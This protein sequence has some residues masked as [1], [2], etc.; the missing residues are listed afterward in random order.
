MTPK[1]RK[2]LEHQAIPKITTQFH[3]LLDVGWY[4]SA[5]QLAKIWLTIF[6]ALMGVLIAIGQLGIAFGPLIGGA[7]TQ[8]FYV[9]LPIGAVVGALLVFIYIPER[10]TKPALRTVL[11]T[12]IESLDL[13]G[14]TI[15][16]PASIMFLLALQYGGNEYAWNSATVIGLLCG[17]AATFV[18]FLSWEY[19]KGDDAMIPFSMISQK[20]LWSASVTMF[21]FLGALFCSNYYLP[22]YFQAVKNASPTMSGVDILPTILSQVLLAMVSGVMVQTLGY[23]LPWVLA[24]SALTTI[25]YGLLSLLTPST[26][27]A[28]WVGY[29]ILFGLGC[30]SGVTISFIAVQNLVAPEKIPIAMGVLV[31]C[32]NFG[33]AL[34]LEVAQ[35]VFTNSLTS[36]IK[37]H[38][39]GVN[40]DAVVQAGARGIRSVVTS[41]QLPAVLKAYTDGV[42]NVMYLGIGLSAG[43][44]CFAW[45]L[46][47]KDIRKAKAAKPSE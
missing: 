28:K 23:Y 27:T 15:F 30:G 42:V 34:W 3:S 11:S 16:A 8:C 36:S 26:P 32:Q 29:Q 10:G 25:A 37:K 18:I 12:A 46:G 4:G 43:A 40:P 9:N 13:V 22:I 5:Y 20:I 6:T 38:A 47:W 41:D 1:T 7:F 39:A 17:A 33:G 19:R 2:N 31:F 45:G 35:T 44:F 24:G 14:F 21:F